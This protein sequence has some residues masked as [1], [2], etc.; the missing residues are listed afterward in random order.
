MLSRRQ[1]YRYLLDLHCQISLN[2]HQAIDNLEA[3]VR[4][5]SATDML[6]GFDVGNSFQPTFNFKYLISDLGIGGKLIGRV[7]SVMPCVGEIEEEGFPKE[8]RNGALLIRTTLAYSI[9]PLI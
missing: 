7:I 6:H 5:T 9:N 2:T 4:A 3:F 1:A 8:N